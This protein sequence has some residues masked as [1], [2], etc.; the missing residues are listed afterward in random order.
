MSSVIV[1]NGIS[2]TIPDTNDVSWG[3]SVTAYLK[4]IPGG[5][6]AKTGGAWELTAADLDLGTAFGVAAP[7]FKSNAASISASGVLRLSLTDLITWRK[8]GSSDYRL[9]VG[10]NGF[11][12]WETIDLVDVSSAQILS[13][14]LIDA[15]LNTILNLTSLNLSPTAGIT[16]SQLQINPGEIPYS[17]LALS[18]QITN[19]DISPTANIDGSKVNTDFGP[20]QVITSGGLRL[21]T[22]NHVTLN[23]DPSADY[24]FIFP[25]TDGVDGQ[26][27]VRQSGELVWA[28]IPGL[29]LPQNNLTIG[30]AGS[31]PQATDTASLGDILADSTTGLTIKNTVI[32]DAMV[33]DTAAVALTKLA[34]Q[35]ASMALVT[36]ASGFIV[37]ATTTAAEIGYVNGVTSSIQDQIDAI[38]IPAQTVIVD[39]LGGSFSSIQLAIDSITDASA[40]KPY[41]VKVYPGVY[42][43]EIVL[44]DWVFV[45]GIDPNSCELYSATAPVTGTLSAGARSGID[46]MVILHRPNSTATLSAIEVTGDFLFSRLVVDIETGASFN[47]VL[48]GIKCSSTSITSIG[49]IQMNLRA[50]LGTITD[51]CGYEFSG[52]QAISFYQSSLY[53]LTALASGTFKGCC[54]SNTGDI[55]AR[56]LDMIIQ[57]F[58]GAF[59]G[60]VIGYNCDTAASSTSVIR[61]VQ[62]SSSL[63]RGA[64]T[65]TAYSSNLDSTG[66]SAK[67]RFDNMSVHING[68]ANEYVANTGTTDSQS[69]WI[70]SLNKD[71]PQNAA[72]LSVSTPQDQNW[73]GF[74][75]WGGSGSYWSYVVGTRVFTLLRD[76]AGV[77]KSTPVTWAA[78][79]TVTLTDL[80]TN[81]VYVNSLGVVGSTT[82]S[83]DIIYTNNVVLFQVWSDG[84]N[85]QVTKENH[86]YEY[87]TAVSKWAHKTFGPL[88]TGLGATITLLGATSARNLAIVG[89]DTILDHGLESSI[90]SAPAVAASWYN[91]YTNGAGK[92]IQDGNAETAILSRY[93]N[94]GTADNATNGRRIVKRLG[95]IKDSLNAATPIFVSV[96]NTATF[97]TD[98]AALTAISNGNIVAFP[99]ELKALEVV[100]LGFVVINSNGAG[101]GTIINNGV[102]VSKQAFGASLIGSSASNQASLI[103]TTTTNFNRALSGADTTSQ[104]AFDTIDDTMVTPTTTDTLTNKTLTAPVITDFE[105][106]TEI[107]TPANPSAGSLKVYAKTDDKLYTLNSAG[108]ESAV[109]SGSGSS[110]EINYISNPLFEETANAATPSGWLTYADAAAATPVDGTGGSPTVTFTASTSSPIRG[111]VSAVFTKDAANRQGEGVAYAFTIPAVDKG[112][113]VGINFDITP[114]GSY[115]SSDMSV[116]VYDVTN[117]ALLTPAAVGIPNNVGTFTTSFGLTAGTSYRL[118]L[119]VASTNASAYTLKV[120][121]VSVGYKPTPQGAVVEEW[122]SYTPTVS[123]ITSNVTHSGTYRRVGS[124]I[125][126]K[127][128]SVFSNTNTQGA[129]G[130]ALASAL[131]AGLTVNPSAL[132]LPSTTQKYITIGTWQAYTSVTNASFGGI[133]SYRQETGAF[134]LHFATAA[135]S[136]S[137]VDT[138]S[139]IPFTIGNGD[140]FSIDLSIPIAEWAGS[141]TVNLAQNDVEFAYNTDTTNADNTVAFGYGSSGVLFPNRAVGTQVTKYVRFS[142]IQPTDK[143]IVEY[144]TSAASEQWYDTQY[145]FPR[146]AQKTNF[147]G[148]ELSRVSSTDVAVVFKAGGAIANGTNYGDNGQ[149]FSDYNF[150]NFYWRVRK[151][152]AGAAVGFGIVQPGVSAGLVSAS[153]LPG[154]TDGAA[155]ASGYVGEVKK[156]E[157]IAASTSGG[158]GTLVS[159]TNALSLGVGNWLITYN[160]SAGLANTPQ[161]D[162][163]VKLDFYIYN[164]TDASFLASCAA[165]AYIYKDAGGNIVPSSSWTGTC[166]IVATLNVTS[167]TKS[168]TGKI[169]NTLVSGDGT[170]NWTSV[171]S[172]TAGLT[173]VRI[174]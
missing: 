94:A 157:A 104:A 139:N 20:S 160:G 97:A 163:G 121:N 9:G 164:D 101:A 71:I 91:Y 129:F 111:L 57:S 171:A 49:L 56:E 70:T 156:A 8:D 67:L 137:T 161:T 38:K 22:T 75:R 2:Y 12:T 30:D 106:Y 5:V 58:N 51:F 26:A 172:S 13:N 29:S 79:Q 76:G 150:V 148:I 86:P 48:S 95:V 158:S 45:S 15:N 7:Y 40:V 135:T 96:L 80:A 130:G 174:A 84:T 47:G 124:S 120:D 31:L 147:Y 142:N 27:L 11:A 98:N 24:D 18:G 109:G 134:F 168:I 50:S 169:G 33:N 107:A 162:K 125:T 14:K 34:A 155:V 65:G 54:L 46:G 140:T 173:A 90:T 61:L 64:G 136:A 23:A 62:A 102:V 100:Q 44:K 19:A 93:N 43:E 39:K 167:G 143:L 32:T 103:T 145:L 108:V 85:Y 73:S 99:A 55:L 69:L 166:G 115:A 117:S 105:S 151:T 4:A 25:D 3:A 123:T 28:S 68:F 113:L 165:A 132:P 114:A 149:P 21:G 144:K 127:I 118:I 89:D 36:D 170:G 74:V 88:I 122:K 41:V 126:C 110:S 141:G 83:S 153:G 16:Y 77:V 35:T 10:A 60:T 81:Y 146:I 119:H 66:N 112:K 138:N 116:Y 128:T 82:S 131:P 152:S 37:P 6:L 59:A 63:L 133:V 52:S 42:A 53:A 17:V 1:F 78:N 72:G 87:T 92:M 159:S 154:R